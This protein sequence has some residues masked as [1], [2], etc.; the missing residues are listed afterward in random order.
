MQTTPAE[1]PVVS[2]MAAEVPTRLART[3]AGH[4][5]EA[6][7]CAWERSGSRLATAGADKTVRLWDAEGHQ[8][9]CLHV[10]CFLGAPGS[11]SKT[12]CALMSVTDLHMSTTED[13]DAQTLVPP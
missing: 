10:R 4:R 9:S 8:I 2:A 12:T 11:C 5:G 3:M 1:A 13:R 7:G 6:F